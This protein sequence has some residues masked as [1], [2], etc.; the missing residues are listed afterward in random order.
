MVR[1]DRD[2]LQCRLYTVR[3]VSSR[4][5]GYHPLLVS[6]KK[7]PKSSWPLA[8]WDVQVAVGCKSGLVLMD[9]THIMN[10]IIR[11]VTWIYQS[12]SFELSA[13][14]L[15]CFGEFA[16]QKIASRKCRYLGLARGASKWI[17]PDSI[18]SCTILSD[19][20]FKWFC[21]RMIPVSDD[22]VFKWFSDDPVL[23]EPILKLFYSGR[24]GNLPEVQPVARFVMQ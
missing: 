5:I 1:L 6:T 7:P 14:L 22:T 16:T 24:F 2:G 19:S 10:R 4:S 23:S 20:G 3:T 11:T 18:L 17:G 12:A 15:N 13:N 21:S 8:V 9:L